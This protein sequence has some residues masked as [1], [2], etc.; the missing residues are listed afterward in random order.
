M[1]IHTGM[2]SSLFY[3]N[4]LLSTT[5]LTNRLIVTYIDNTNYLSIYL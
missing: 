4:S 2:P 1:S 3:S 5:V